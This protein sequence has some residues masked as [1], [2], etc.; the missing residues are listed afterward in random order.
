M[1]TRIEAAATAYKRGWLRRGALHLSDVA[2]SACLQRAGREPRELD[3]LI[4]AGI[5]KDANA[6]E[7][8]LASIIQA[9][10][11]AN[12]GTRLEGGHGTFSFDVLNGGCGVITAAQI[13]AT[14][15]GHGTARHGLIV[16][17]DVDPSPRTS[18][19]YPFAPAGGAMLVS[20]VRGAVGFQGFEL[21][22]F[23]AHA[24]LFEVTLR[25][26]PRA[27]FAH[28][29]RNVVEV[30]EAPEFAGRCRELAAEV[31]SAFLARHH[32]EPDEIDLLIT[33]QYPSEIAGQLAGRIGIPDDRVPRVRPELAHAHT[34]GPIA[35]LEVA[36][37]SGQFARARRT[38]FVTVGAGITVGVALYVRDG[39]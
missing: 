13:L 15:V 2:A 32:L 38:L 19:Q 11:G 8:A 39:A 30:R 31:A 37:A 36:F 6:A 18:K 27:G 9:D 17:G 28:R 24:E 3:L 33:S 25:W 35:A 29:G 14:F 1:G 10:L 5:Y 20:Y 22:T 23:P 4:N 7:P 16:A 12:R 34:A 21:R 26:D